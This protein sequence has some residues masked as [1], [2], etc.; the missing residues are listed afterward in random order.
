MITTSIVGTITL[1][2]HG[3]DLR[4]LAMLDVLLSFLI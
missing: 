1:P 4:T 2:D 3:T